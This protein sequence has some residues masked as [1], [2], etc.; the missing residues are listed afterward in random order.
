M[1]RKVGI[2]GRGKITPRHQIR[3]AGF[4]SVPK[5]QTPTG[6]RI[7]SGQARESGRLA[8]RPISKPPDKSRSRRF[9]ISRVSPDGSCLLC[10]VAILQTEIHRARKE[11]S[12]MDKEGDCHLERFF[13]TL[14]FK[15]PSAPLRRGT[16]PFR[17]R[18]GGGRKTPAI[19]W[20]VDGRFYF[21]GCCPS[22]IGRPPG[23]LCEKQQ[24]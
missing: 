5:R 17:G 3:S 18:M 2:H 11:R 9:R 21:A 22:T 10:M 7:A 1:N 14:H 4:A 6:G 12:T 19:P 15:L 20:R 23:F 13:I 24:P 16:S 8:A